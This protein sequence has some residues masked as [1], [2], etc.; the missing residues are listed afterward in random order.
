METEVHIQK[1]LGNGESTR[2]VGNCSLHKCG[3]TVKQLKQRECLQKQ[4]KHFNKHK[5]HPYWKQRSV[6]SQRRKA[7]KQ[8]LLYGKSDNEDTLIE[9]TIDNE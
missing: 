3:L 7:R 8:Q 4:C 5:G 6:I 9:E 2:C 1:T